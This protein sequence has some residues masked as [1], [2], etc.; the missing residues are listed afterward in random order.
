MKPIRDFVGRELRWTQPSVTKM[1]YELRTGEEVL[2]TLRFRR[3]FGSFAT[4]ESADGAWT[5]KRVGFWQNRTA[6][7]SVGSD[8]EIGFFRTNAWPNGGTLELP[9]GRH[10]PASTNFWMTEYAFQTGDGHPLVVYRKIGGLV[11]LSSLV[12]LRPTAATLEEA[13]WIVSLGWYLTVM[14]QTTFR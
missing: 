2:S 12:E 1:E 5:F 6:V 9:D 10:Y 13:P 14:L 8:L 4:A 11:H 7:R 3:L